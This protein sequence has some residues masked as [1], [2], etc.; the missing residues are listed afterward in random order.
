[1]TTRV[2]ATFSDNG[3]I[4]VYGDAAPMIHVSASVRA[5]DTTSGDLLWQ[6]ELERPFLSL[7]IVGSR[8]LVDL[9]AERADGQY[10]NGSVAELVQVVDLETGETL[11]EVMSDLLIIAAG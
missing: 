11:N 8:L 6:A 4:V 5:R 3:S 7:T 9:P 1:M 2:G 10:L